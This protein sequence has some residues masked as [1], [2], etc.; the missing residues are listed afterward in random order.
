[1]VLNM[2]DGGFLPKR[3]R[4]FERGDLAV[5]IG[6]CRGEVIDDLYLHGVLPG[7]LLIGE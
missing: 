3:P 6:E 5:P 7:R 4:Q 2:E 1:M